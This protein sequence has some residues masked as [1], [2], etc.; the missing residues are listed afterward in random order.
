M[1]ILKAIPL[2]AVRLA[3][4][5][6]AAQ[7]SG[8]IRGACFAAFS[9]CPLVGVDCEDTLRGMKPYRVGRCHFLPVTRGNLDQV[10][11]RTRRER[12][13]QEV[14]RTW[15]AGYRALQTEFSARK[16]GAA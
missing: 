4:V 5:T 6:A 12:G 16:G 3:H 15:G 11:E 13:L 1:A 14:R 8:L 9:D 7:A 2:D 10:L